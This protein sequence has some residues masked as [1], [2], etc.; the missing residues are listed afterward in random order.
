MS[1][2]RHVA[3][4]EGDIDVTPMLDVVFILLIF[5]VVT[6]SFVREPGFDPQRSTAREAQHQAGAEILV[7]VTPAGRIWMHGE[8]VSLDEVSVKATQELAVAPA[9]TA[10][11]I[12]D[13][14]APAGV[15]LD[16]MNALRL[17]GVSDTTLGATRVDN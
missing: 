1:R 7:A 10:I 17:A 9:A 14:D 4:Q 2:L 16:V 11:V 12:G 8:P 15:L 3:E 6:T 13:R 5:F